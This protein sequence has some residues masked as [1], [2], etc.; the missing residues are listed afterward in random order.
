MPKPARGLNG[1]PEPNTEQYSFSWIV[2]PTTAISRLI[3][4]SVRA[5]RRQL[6][7][8]DATAGNVH[9]AKDQ[10]E[11]SLSEAERPPKFGEEGAFRADARS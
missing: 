10:E 11:L 3:P 2:R 8:G 4:I 1:T 9:R 5:Q 7:S 6:S